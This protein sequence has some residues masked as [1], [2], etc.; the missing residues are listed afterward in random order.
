[1]MLHTSLVPLIRLDLSAIKQATD[2][3]LNEAG[4][5]FTKMLLM[6][7]DE[8]PHYY[9]ENR[10]RISKWSWAFHF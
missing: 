9:E 4:A 7:E 2:V 6:D 5:E 10:D 1:M 8:G 3:G